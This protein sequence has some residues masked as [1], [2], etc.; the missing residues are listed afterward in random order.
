MR[1]RDPVSLPASPVYVN[2][3]VPVPVPGPTNVH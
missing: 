2:G 3:N 1:S